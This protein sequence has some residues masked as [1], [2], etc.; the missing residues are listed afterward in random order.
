MRRFLAVLILLLP[1]PALADGWIEVLEIPLMPELELVVD[2]ETVFET[3]AG[4]VIE[5]LATGPVAPEAARRYYAT[6]LP[7]LGWRASPDGAMLRDDE[8]LEIETIEGGGTTTVIFRLVPD[9]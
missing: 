5:V 9:R 1:F 7:G 6:A 2:G 4:R 8:R 3:S